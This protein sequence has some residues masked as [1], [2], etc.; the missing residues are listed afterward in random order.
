MIKFTDH[1]AWQKALWKAEQNLKIIEEAKPYYYILYE[2][3]VSLIQYGP[4]WTVKRTIQERGYNGLVNVFMECMEKW[5][6]LPYYQSELL[7]DIVKD[8][9]ID[10]GILRKKGFDVKKIYETLK[11]LK[12]NKSKEIICQ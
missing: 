3:M 4:Y 5:N 9:N 12:S 6:A 11:G 1:N 8:Y 10:A 7:W 2:Y